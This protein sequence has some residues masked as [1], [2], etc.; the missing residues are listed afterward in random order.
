MSIL[1][2]HQEKGIIKLNQN[3]KS[4]RIENGMI[5]RLLKAH[6]LH[7]RIPKSKDPGINSRIEG[8]NT[9]ATESRTQIDGITET[10]EDKIL[11]INIE[12]DEML[13][14]QKSCYYIL[15]L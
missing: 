1:E 7:P 6:L 10:R 3:C 14:I 9:R 2:I 4:N 13:M 12:G 11:P 8:D 15:Y 5:L